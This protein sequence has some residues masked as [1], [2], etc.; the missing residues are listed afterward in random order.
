LQLALYK[1]SKR[2]I[3]EKDEFKEIN[4]E[5]S[6]CIET[7]QEKGFYKECFCYIKLFADNFLPTVP[8]DYQ[9]EI[10]EYCFKK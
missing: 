4:D 8:E 1:F 7:L 6:S 2:K 5:F 10:R 9:K 3:D